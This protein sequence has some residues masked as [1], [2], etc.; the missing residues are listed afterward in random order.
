VTPSAKPNRYAHLGLEWPSDK[1]EHPFSVFDSIFGFTRRPVF[2][3]IDLLLR[4]IDFANDDVGLDI[5]EDKY[6]EAIAFERDEF[7]NLGK[8]GEPDFEAFHKRI[9]RFI[10]PAEVNALIARDRKNA[11]N[12]LHAA[13]TTPQKLGEWL[14]IWRTKNESGEI[15]IVRRPSLGLGSKGEVQINWR[16]EADEFSKGALISHSL[17]YA[18]ALL[19]T[20]HQGCRSNLGYC[21]LAGCGRFFEVERGK[22][23]KPRRDYCSTAHMKAAHE[24]DSARRHRDSRDRKKAEAGKK[25]R[26]R[27]T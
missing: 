6:R 13:A 24:R 4:I 26:R 8:D 21:R 2:D 15:G 5:V 25:R 27:S 16:L 20:D 10:D 23:G 22:P 11:A 19:L 3:D 1:F 17:A 14:R 7:P 12:V 18:A 9:R